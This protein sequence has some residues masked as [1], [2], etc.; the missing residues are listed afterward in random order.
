MQF[1]YVASEKSGK[2]VEG[3]AEANGEAQVL[4]YLAERGMQPIRVISAEE[5]ARAQ[6]KKGLFG[7]SISISEKIF[8]TKYLGI[9]LKAGTD[10]FRAIDILI[11]DFSKP[12]VKNFM[13]EVRESLERGE[14]FHTTFE[15]YPKY[16]SPIFVN[17]VKAG[18]SSGKLDEVLGDLTVALEKEKELKG[19]LK[20]ALVYPMLLVVMAMAILTFLVT[21]ALPKIAE[22]FSGGGIE[23][24]LF[25]RIVFGIGLFLSK[26]IIAMLML[27]I[28]ALVGLGFF[29]FKTERGKRAWATFLTKV[30][31]V[32]SVIEKLALE[33]FAS[34][35]SALLKAGMP[36]VTALQLTANAVGNEKLSISLRRIAAEGISKGLT[37]GEAFKREEAFPQVVSNLIAVSEKAGHLDDILR[38]LS[39]FYEK[40]IDGAV[41]TL[42]SFLEPALLIVIGGVVG[43]IA[44]SIIVP[45]YQ[46]VGQF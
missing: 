9:M 21:F 20:S 22:V 13:I 34:T 28:G 32:K 14:Q 12:A 35:L 40:E 39:E 3:N 10:I 27:G 5:R 2:I 43:V 25:S 1:H 23:P 19:K 42:V 44:L 15:R 33:R 37:V 4:R 46:L 18:E 45:I 38:T 17:L 24:P 11:A 16:F 26:Y 41:K 8:I 31:V 30:P 29:F 36:I 6:K 7:G